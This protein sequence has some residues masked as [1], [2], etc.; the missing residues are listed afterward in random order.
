MKYISLIVNNEIVDQIKVKSDSIEMV[1]E[2]DDM[3][4]KANILQDNQEI[5][6]TEDV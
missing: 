4:R 2:I 3:L 6:I 1:M 5:A